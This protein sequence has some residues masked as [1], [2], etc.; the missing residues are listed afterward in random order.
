VKLH[1][2]G[3]KCVSNKNFVCTSENNVVRS[4]FSREHSDHDYISLSGSSNYHPCSLQ[5][6]LENQRIKQAALQ[7]KVKADLSHLQRMRR[8]MGALDQQQ[9]PSV[10]A[11]ATATV[12]RSTQTA[13]SPLHIASTA[14][15]AKKTSMTGSLGQKVAS[16]EAQAYKAEAK[17]K[18]LEQ[19]AHQLEQLRKAQGEIVVPMRTLAHQAQKTVKGA[20]EAGGAQITGLTGKYVAKCND[21]GDCVKSYEPETYESYAA[22]EN[23]TAMVSA[24]GIGYPLGPTVRPTSA[25]YR[26]HSASKVAHPCMLIDAEPVPCLFSLPMMLGDAYAEASHSCQYD[27]SIVFA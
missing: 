18:A 15:L 6:Q 1:F 11:P 10:K 23:H 20:K 7:A 25:V 19:T 3:N 13:S 21:K 4:Y 12:L 5:L 24:N 16:L 22:N 27:V 14:K 26:L 17:A 8:E 2:P 9:K